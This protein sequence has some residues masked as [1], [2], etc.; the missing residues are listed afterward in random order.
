MKD[1]QFIPYIVS[2]DF[3]CTKFRMLFDVAVSR[4]EMGAETTI[5]SH[6]PS[7]SFVLTR[8]LGVLSRMGKSEVLT[9]LNEPVVSP[10][11]SPIPVQS[12]RLEKLLV[13]TIR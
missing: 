13:D 2:S 1:V 9:P 11:T 3:A 10:L 4:V 8:K 7:Y 5:A 12:K 6:W